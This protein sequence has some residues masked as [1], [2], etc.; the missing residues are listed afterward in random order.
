MADANTHHNDSSADNVPIS[1]A[2]VHQQGWKILLF[3]AFFFH[4]DTY[5]E[6]ALFSLPLELRF[7]IYD[8]AM[9]VCPYVE[10]GCITVDSQEHMQA[11]A[12]LSGV[13]RQIRCEMLAWLVRQWCVTGLSMTMSR[14]IL[15]TNASMMRFDAFCK[16]PDEWK[17]FY[18]GAPCNFKFGNLYLFLHVPYCGLVI[19]QIDFR[20]REVVVEGNKVDPSCSRLSQRSLRETEELSAEALQTSKESFTKAMHEVVDQEGFDRF[21]L[22]DF[23]LLLRNLKLSD[24]EP[25]GDFSL[26]FEEVDPAENENPSKFIGYD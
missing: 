10:L 5:L 11:M 13:S 3:V 26:L 4:T 20:K 16:G 21:T 7:L 2:V 25:S 1:T 22:Q 18:T 23:H 14:R 12:Q 19:A 17:D 15:P 9:H 24:I 8:Y 6:S